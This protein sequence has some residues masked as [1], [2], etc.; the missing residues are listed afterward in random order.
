MTDATSDRTTPA[1]DPSRY[2]M[3]GQNVDF[4]QFFRALSK[5]GTGQMYVLR[6]FFEDSGKFDQW[7]VKW[8]E[9]ATRE[10]IPTDVRVS[11]M[12]RVNPIYIPRNHRVEEALAAAVQDA[13]FSR[14]E[15]LLKVLS[16]PFDERQGLDDYA[17]PAPGDFGPYKTFCGT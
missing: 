3:N 6:N 4:T 12:N 9:R 13:D 1:R 5:T 8:Q 7:H 2:M 16:K 10:A 15:R 14:F 11:A 17:Q